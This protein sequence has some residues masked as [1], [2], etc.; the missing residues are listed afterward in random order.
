M[1]TYKVKWKR[2]WWMPY[3]NVT[4]KLRGHQYI[5]EADRMVFY[6]ENGSQQEIVSWSKCEVILGTD[7][8]LATKEYMEKQANQ[9]VAL[10]VKV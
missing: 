10:N 3:W 8:V 1:S 2:R 7:W 6:F 4:K 5:K 9:A